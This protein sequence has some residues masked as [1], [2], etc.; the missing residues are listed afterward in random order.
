MITFEKEYFQTFE[1][2]KS[3]IER[4]FR[5][6]LRDLEIA[7]KDSFS[8]VRFSYSY[9]ALIKA[10]IALLAKKNKKVR[11]TSGHH[12]KILAK[13]SEILHDEDILIIGNAM[14]MKRNY[15]L[16]G[17]GESITEKEAKDYLDFVEKIFVKA[18]K[19]IHS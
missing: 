9:Q 18:K 19:E 8:E 17:G 4:Y 7:R 5:G 13:M 2:S 14:R 16:Y 3:Q 10:G 1:F 6:A 12:V 11:S 15:D